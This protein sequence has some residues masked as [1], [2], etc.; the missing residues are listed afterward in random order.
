MKLSILSLSLTLSCAAVAVAV[1][2][3]PE[4]IPPNIRPPQGSV[5][6]LQ[7]QAQGEQ[8]YQCTLEAGQI[9]WQFKAP[10][11]VLFDA[12]GRQIGRH[13]AGPTWE[14]NDG[15]RIT[16]KLVRK[17]DATT[18]K[19]VPWL[20]LETVEHKGAGQLAATRYINR[21]DTQGGMSPEAKCDGNRLGSE[22]RVR[23][24]AKYLFYTAPAL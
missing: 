19:A 21:I 1:A 11:A 23:Y 4:D 15:S 8:I 17:Q 12:Q 6:I 22:A 18:A 2:A 13:Y 7:T 16:A 24:Q 5:L 10:D 20:L 3:A 9:Q 14:F